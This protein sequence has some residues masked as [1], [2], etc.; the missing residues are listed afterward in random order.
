MILFLLAVGLL[1]RYAGIEF[2]CQKAYYN[3]SIIF[4]G[5]VK[6]YP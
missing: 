2:P 6:V 3:L 1:G 4:Y 5:M